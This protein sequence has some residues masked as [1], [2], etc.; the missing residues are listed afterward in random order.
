MC[1]FSAKFCLMV[2]RCFWLV[3]MLLSAAAAH[4][5]PRIPPSDAAVLER[6]PTKP[7]DASARALRRLR[8]AVVSAPSEPDPAAALA[9]RYFELAMA[10]GDPRYVGYAEGVLLPWRGRSDAPTGILVLQGLL[11]QY[12]HDFDGALRQLASALEREP[13]LVEAHAWR[14]A[15]YMVQAKYELALVEC[16]ALSGFASEMLETGCRS[17]VEGV[18]GSAAAAYARLK[19]V[20][21]RFPRAAPDLKVW[22]QTRLAELAWRLDRKTQAESHF[23][24]ALTLGITDNYLLA[25]FADFLLE[26][27]RPAEVLRLLRDRERSDTLLLRIALAEHATKAATATARARILG[28]RFHDAALRDERLHLAEE[29]RFLLTLRVDPKAA[30]LA[31]LENWKTQREPRDAEILLEA[32]LAAGKP[33]AAEPVLSWLSATGCEG[34]RLARLAEKLRPVRR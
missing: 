22:I 10:E 34:A 7:A 29:A 15:I 6:L 1:C 16:A 31:A 26:E 32:A 8:D 14:A 24:D 23:R 20:S 13:H 2:V 28:E 17:S 30:L 19:A 27:G 33:T 4:A 21:E 3:G 12:R 5:A 18:T 25:A 11:R 9:R